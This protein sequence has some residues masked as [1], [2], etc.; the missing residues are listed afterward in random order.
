MCDNLNGLNWMATFGPPFA[1]YVQK[2]QLTNSLKFKLLKP[3]QFRYLF[4]P[5]Y[6]SIQKLPFFVYKHVS[7]NNKQKTSNM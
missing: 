2:Y 5:Y 4:S 7:H 1:H 3:K 6:F